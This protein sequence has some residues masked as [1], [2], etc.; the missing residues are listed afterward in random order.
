[1]TVKTN[2]VQVGPCLPVGVKQCLLVT[3]SSG[4]IVLE[5][6]SFVEDRKRVNS[7]LL[8]YLPRVYFR[9]DPIPYVS[10]LLEFVALRLATLAELVRL[11][12]FRGAAILVTFFVRT[13]FVFAPPLVQHGELRTLLFVRYSEHQKLVQL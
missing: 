4:M 5:S 11:V 13:G 12:V 7:G 8:D 2:S 1:M 3:Q 10:F 6:Q 9:A